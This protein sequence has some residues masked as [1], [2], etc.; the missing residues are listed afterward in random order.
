MSPIVSIVSIVSKTLRGSPTQ[1]YRRGLRA[2]VAAAALCCVL[3]AASARGDVS[4]E[5]KAASQT[6]FDEGRQLMARGQYEE[7]CPKLAES[8][9][10]DPG[11]GTQYNFADCLEHVANQ[12]PPSPV[13]R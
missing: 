8:Q 6:L 9:R 4:L 3:P 10:L 13:L 2:G 11:I 5:H 7:A 12:T 1:T